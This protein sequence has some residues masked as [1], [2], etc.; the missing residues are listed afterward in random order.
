[1]STEKEKLIISLKKQGKTIRQIAEQTQSSFS[2]ISNILK[3]AEDE[4]RKLAQKKTVGEEETQKGARYTQAMKMFS[5]GKSTI[6]VVKKISGMKADEVLA[7][8]ADYLELK[9]AKELARAYRE[10]RPYLS[11]LLRL[12]ERTRQ[13]NITQDD[14]V[15]AMQDVKRLRSLDK[16]IFSA[17]DYLGRL[18]SALNETKNKV[19]HLERKKQ[20]LETM[21]EG[22]E[23]KVLQYRKMFKS[24]RDYQ[25]LEEELDKH[26]KL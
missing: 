20:N 3:K 10:D 26:R 5:R 13:E 25:A 4:E 19:H 7:L 22:Y 15:L 14:F 2:T 6:D 18:E 17:I 8:H 21:I 23:N 16:K 12:Y 9:K 24:F 11:S 1:M